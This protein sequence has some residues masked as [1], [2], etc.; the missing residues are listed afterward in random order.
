MTGKKRGFQN[1]SDYL[2]ESS[3]VNFVCSH[4]LP[5]IPLSQCSLYTVSLR[6][7]LALANLICLFFRSLDSFFCLET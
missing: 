3:F 7:K 5:P 2:E 1:L 6:F 4:S